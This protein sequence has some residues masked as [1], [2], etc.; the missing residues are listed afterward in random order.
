MTPENQQ[1]S[2]LLLSD[3]QVAK[4][5]GCHRNTIWNRVRNDQLPSPI[6]WEGK[7]VWRRRDI[8][9]FVAAL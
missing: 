4:L 7:T 5:L 8:E 9:E 2:P 3:K 1:F 6:K